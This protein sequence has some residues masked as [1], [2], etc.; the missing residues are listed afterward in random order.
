[1]T[2]RGVSM[3]ST[4]KIAKEQRALRLGKCPE[5]VSE[6]LVTDKDSGEIICSRCGLVLKA[7]MLNQT[8]EW[9]AFTPEEKKSKTRVGPPTSLTYYDKGLSTTFRTSQDRYGKGLSAKTLIE[10]GFNYVC[11]LDGVKLFRK[12]QSGVGVSKS[13]VG[14]I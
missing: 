11:E 5:C 10:T 9:R 2:R 8:P 12:R 7:I 13:G 1:V 3:L 4:V 14:G 6:E